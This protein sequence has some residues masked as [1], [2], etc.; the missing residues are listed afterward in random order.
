M[1]AVSATPTVFATVHAKPDS[2]E[3]TT[4]ELP[5]TERKIMIPVRAKKER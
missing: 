4:N 3:T 1:L 5:L 2:P